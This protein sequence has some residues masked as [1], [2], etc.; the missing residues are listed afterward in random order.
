[1]KKINLCVYKALDINAAKHWTWCHDKRSCH[2][3]PVG[4]CQAVAYLPDHF[5][6]TWPLVA[7]SYK[8]PC[9]ACSTGVQ[10]QPPATW[11]ATSKCSVNM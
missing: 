6:A 10:N 7:V 1:M 4:S 9:M 3:S 2:S 8:S 5:W 11:G